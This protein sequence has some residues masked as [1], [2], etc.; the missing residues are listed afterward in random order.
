ML[1]PN[2]IPPLIISGALL[3]ISIAIFWIWF[4]LMDR[5]V[6]RLEGKD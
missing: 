3:V 4:N 5:R 6:R 1:N 2:W